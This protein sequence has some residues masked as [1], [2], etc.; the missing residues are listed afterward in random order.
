MPS[1]Q[2]GARSASAWQYFWRPWQVGQV[3]FAT[4]GLLDCGCGDRGRRLRMHRRKV[5]ILIASARCAQAHRGRIHIA[6]GEGSAAPQPGPRGGRLLARCSHPF[7]PTAAPARP[8]PQ[9]SPPA[10]PS[11]PWR[12]SSA[13]RSRPLA[14]AFADAS[15]VVH[16]A[17]TSAVPIVVRNDTL[18]GC[19]WA[20]Q[21]GRWARQVRGSWSLLCMGHS[22]P[23][24]IARRGA[25][26]CACRPS[27]GL[28][29]QP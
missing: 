9:Q 1:C 21:R 27:Q 26:A 24:A 25:S 7:Q 19:T 20:Q 5:A 22:Q 11:R 28:A 6:H 2:S 4:V 10:A 15:V 8:P 12:S 23:F 3:A 17:T 14:M 13:K 29:P 16:S 18:V